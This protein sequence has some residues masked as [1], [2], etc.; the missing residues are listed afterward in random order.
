MG[1]EVR[2]AQYIEEFHTNLLTLHQDYRDAI[3]DDSPFADWT[4]IPVDSAF[5]G[6]GYLIS[7]F[8]SLYDM[9]GKFM[10]GLDIDALYTQIY[11]DTVE[12]TVID[13]LVAAEA[14]LLEDDIDTNILPRFETG[15]RDIN[16]VMSS[17]FVIGKALIEATRVKAVAK[18]SAGLKYQMIPVA[19]ERWKGHLEWNKGVVMTYAEIMKLYYSAKMDIT[20]VNYSMAVKDMLWPFTVLDFNR[21]AA[22]ALNGATASTEIA[23]TS[24]AGK[25]IAGALGGA[26]TGLMAGTAIGGFVGVGTGAATG[27]MIGMPAGPFGALIGGAL[28]LAAG[29]LS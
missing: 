9:Y 12:S 15:M 5:F 2:F 24:R 3:R 20:D 19:A 7:S 26:A 22:G 6:T 27:A 14:D 10:A 28:G 18:F 4:D 13:D 21:A 11:A 23:G 17:S 16:A 8:P 25:V 29:L 1:G